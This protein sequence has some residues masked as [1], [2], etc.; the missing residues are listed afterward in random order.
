MRE[1]NCSQPE[2]Y[3]GSL[4][5]QRDNKWKQTCLG[6]E[7]VHFYGNRESELNLRKMCR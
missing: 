3:L 1:Q 7:P 4:K 6:T 2:C 5:R